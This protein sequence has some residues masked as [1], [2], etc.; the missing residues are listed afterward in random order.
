MFYWNYNSIDALVVYHGT[1]GKRHGGYDNLENYLIGYKL[2][3]DLVVT[4]S[5]SKQYFTASAKNRYIRSV[6][7]EATTTT[8]G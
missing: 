3:E 5:T 6:T 4:P 7:V 1:T 8:A 2:P